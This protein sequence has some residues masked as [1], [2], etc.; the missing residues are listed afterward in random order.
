MTDSEAGPGGSESAAARSPPDGAPAPGARA[1]VAP[2]PRGPSPSRP[3]GTPAAPPTRG[4]G[5]GPLRGVER[6]RTDP[7]RSRVSGVASGSGRASAGLG[8]AGGLHPRRP[9]GPAAT[10]PGHRRLAAGLSLR[11]RGRFRPGSGS[12]GARS[13][14][15][16]G[17]RS[18]SRR[19]GPPRRPRRRRGHGGDP[20]L[21]HRSLLSERAPAAPGED[22][23]VRPGALRVP[24]EDPTPRPEL[25][26]T[27]PDHCRPLPT[28]S[29]WWRRP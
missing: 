28:S 13:V 10:H 24:T 11:S 22:P 14:R 21:G 18:R 3:R 4:A 25:P 2:R 16:L 17:P 5:D 9:P 6:R 19:P 27:K 7:A 23:D 15:R 12:G 29:W 1:E 8:S 20:G 26:P